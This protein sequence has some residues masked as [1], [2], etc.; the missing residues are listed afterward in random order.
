MG[1]ILEMDFEVVAS[2]GVPKRLIRIAIKGLL[3]CSDKFNKERGAKIPTS[4]DIYSSDQNTLLNSIW[5]SLPGI[6]G[7]QPFSSSMSQWYS[8]S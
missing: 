5:G 3:V 1:F 2:K 4:M 7:L 6:Q 8:P